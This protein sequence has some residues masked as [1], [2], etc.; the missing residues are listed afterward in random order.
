MTPTRARMVDARYITLSGTK[1]QAQAEA[2]KILA[3]IAY[4]SAVNPSAETVAQFIERW[5]RDW[6]E[7]NESAKTLERY[8]GLL[9]NHFAAQIGSIPIQKLRPVDL[10]RVYA[11]MARDGL[12]DRTRLHAHRVMSSA[13]RHATQ[14]GVIPRNPASMV[15]A[16]R[17]KVQEIEILTPAQV[18]LVLAALRGKPSYSVV[19]LMFG[20]GLRR[21]EA[22]ALRW[23]DIDLDGGALPVERSIEQTKRGGLIFKSPKTAHGRRGV[24]LA[25]STIAML[26]E[27]RKSQLERRVLLGLGK[28]SSDALVFT[29][30]DGSSPYLPS[31]LT[32]QWRRA[33]AK[34]GLRA[35]LHSVR[36]VHTS[37]LLTSGL[38]VLTVSRRIGH[39]TPSKTLNVYG[40]LLKPDDRAAAIIEKALAGTEEG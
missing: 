6:A 36:H 15:D 17:V 32:L 27:H 12:A 11:T 33:M 5:L 14:W 31:T 21:S 2:T 34:T 16:P 38:D 3:G 26:R 39:S 7:I 18:Q 25:P 30:E 23:Q 20:T 22:L 13:L 24:S 28:A 37:L 8:A 4:G 9:R 19:A 1:A 10:Q 35:T 40:H 29:A